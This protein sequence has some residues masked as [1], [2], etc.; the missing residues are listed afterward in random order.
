MFAQS[1]PELDALLQLDP[2]V[3]VGVSGGKDSQAAAI[4]T[5][6][7]LD[8][9]GHQG[10]RLLIHADLGMV[11]WNDSLSVYES[12]ARHFGVELII[13]KRK[14]G[15]L[16]ERWESRWL[17]SRRRYEA[18]E[19]V[20][21][22]PCW[23]TPSL[24][25][26]QSET[27]THP[28]MA[29]LRKRYPKQTIVNVTGVRREESARRAKT[30]IVSHDPVTRWTDWRPIADFS[31]GDV[32]QAITD[33]GLTPHPAYS[34]FGMSRVSCRLCIMQS[35]PDMRAAVLRPESHN[36][37][38]RMVALEAESGFAFQ[39]S[40]W[41][42]DIARALLGDDLRDRF[43]NG[44]RRADAR[45][46][47]ESAITPVMRY[48]KGW[49]QRL[50]SQDE[51]G[52]LANIR[53]RVSALYGFHSSCLDPSEIQDRYAALMDMKAERDRG[54]KTCQRMIVA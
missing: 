30:Q 38:R 15:G 39:G 34:C 27:K 50:L 7:H 21:L 51:A 35:L 16:M 42:G 52:I 1:N 11:Q 25:F 32:F 6:R 5:F 54:Q 18:L 33:A 53:Q 28:I 13:V 3:A 47:A 23:S 44:K 2:P 19:T 45:R 46:E 49:P 9:I 26:C 37:Y 10:P 8:A 22:V 48:V 17:S 24:R 41:L 14:A 20:T 43:A 36:L 31:T 40:R 29:A 4:A 12:L